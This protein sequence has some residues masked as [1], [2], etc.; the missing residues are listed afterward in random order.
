M[1]KRPIIPYIGMSNVDDLTAVLY[2]VNLVFLNSYHSPTLYYL[3]FRKMSC[4][5]SMM[6][7]RENL[8]TSVPTTTLISRKPSRWLRSKLASSKT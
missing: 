5:E 8:N 3:T 7:A 4:G 6:L 2:E 1:I